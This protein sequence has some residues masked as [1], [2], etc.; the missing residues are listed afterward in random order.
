MLWFGNKNGRLLCY[1]TS[2]DTYT[3]H[4]LKTHTPIYS[5]LFDS[6][7]RFWVGTGEGLLLFNQDTYATELVPLNQT[8]NQIL[9]IDEDKDGNIWVATSLES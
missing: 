8:I 6:Q 1:N 2:N 5:L 3:I 7:G 9:D 4:P